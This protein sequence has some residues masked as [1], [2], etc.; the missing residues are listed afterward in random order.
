MA[1]AVWA[2]AAGSSSF[3]LTPFKHPQVHDFKEPTFHNETFWLKQLK[4]TD[5]PHGVLDNQICCVFGFSV[6]VF[7]WLFW[8]I[9]QPIT[10]SGQSQALYDSSQTTDRGAHSA[11]LLFARTLSR[12]A[13]HP[14]RLYR[15]LLCRITMTLLY[16]FGNWEKDPGF[17]WGGWGQCTM[18]I[19]HVTVWSE[20]LYHPPYEK[21]CCIF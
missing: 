2:S 7:H 13:H 20:S 10:A 17:F 1:P 15:L 19:S 11:H 9:T 18:N 6:L 5:F 16:M 4:H 8:L 12:R 3:E 21:I 14:H